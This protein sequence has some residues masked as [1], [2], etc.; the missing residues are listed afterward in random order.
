[1]TNDKNTP[2]GLETTQGRLKLLVKLSGLTREEF[3][4]KH[5]IPINTLKSYLDGKRSFPMVDYACEFA[6]EYGVSLDWLYCKTS[7]MCHSD[8][9]ICALSKLLRVES[10]AKKEKRNGEIY[11]YRERTL[12]MDQ[13]LYEFLLAIQELK[14]VK[15]HSITMPE[16]EYQ[17]RRNMVIKKANEELKDIFS[18]E[19][20]GKEIDYLELIDN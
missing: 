1:M 4:K 18:N 8:V 6:D 20:Q 16:E 2:K 12:Y 5:N 3:S 9:L 10:K 13:R 19:F 14:Y 7:F 11:A 17:V 15:E